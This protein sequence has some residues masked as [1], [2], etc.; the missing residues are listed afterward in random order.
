LDVAGPLVALEYLEQTRYANNVGGPTV[1]L[2]KARGTEAAPTAVLLGDSLGSLLFGGYDGAAFQIGRAFV[3][4]VAA[5]NW[6][7]VAQG[8]EL[9]FETTPLGAVNA[10]ERW[11]ML[12]AG[13]FIPNLDNT[14]DIGAAGA[15][16][17]R[18]VYIATSAFVGAQ[19][20]LSGQGAAVADAA[21]G[22]TIDVEARA[23]LNA[24]LAR[25]RASTGHGLI[26][27]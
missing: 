20:V 25:V 18:T 27:G 13:H 24:L 11:K 6:S 3:I 12:P 16:R 4:G 8:S 5:E 10:V 19:R 22:A 17:P 2:R 14:Y 7:P 9:W 23:A 1:R 15:T 21:G 26:A